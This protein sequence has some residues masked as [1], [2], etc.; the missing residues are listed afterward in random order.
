MHS[1]QSSCAGRIGRRANRQQKKF[2]DEP[3]QRVETTGSPADQ[4]TL[5]NEHRVHKW[6][7]SPW[8]AGLPSQSARS[9]HRDEAF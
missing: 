3:L 1:S 9:G 8:A 4:Q 2:V 6:G 5:C 7:G